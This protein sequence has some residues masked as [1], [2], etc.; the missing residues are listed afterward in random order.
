MV[1]PSADDLPDW[2]FNRALLVELCVVSELVLGDLSSTGKT[3]ITVEASSLAEC[4]RCWRRL[5]P[6]GDATHPELCTR[7]AG[8]VAP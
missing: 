8:A 1:H 5:G 2:T 3:E 4:P 6:S 7:C